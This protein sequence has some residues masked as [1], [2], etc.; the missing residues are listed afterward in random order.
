MEGCVCGGSNQVLPEDTASVDLWMSQ[1]W[2]YHVLYR[3]QPKE[4]AVVFP[5]QIVA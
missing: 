2:A 5:S 3:G 4:G 1:P